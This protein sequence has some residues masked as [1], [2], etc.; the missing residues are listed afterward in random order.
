MSTYDPVRT[1]KFGLILLDAGEL[2]QLGQLLSFT[3]DKR[4]K[5]GRRVCVIRTSGV[6]A[7]RSP[8]RL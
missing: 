4:A 6:S 5:F 1:S 3:S 8:W 2:D 7:I